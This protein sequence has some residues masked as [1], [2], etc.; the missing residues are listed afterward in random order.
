MWKLTLGYSNKFTAK[1][2]FWKGTVECA[3]VFLFSTF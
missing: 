2:F 1:I 3:Q